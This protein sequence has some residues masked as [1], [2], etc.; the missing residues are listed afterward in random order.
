MEL[1]M[2]PTF[3]ISSLKIISLTYCQPITNRKHLLRN[4]AELLFLLN[5][6]NKDIVS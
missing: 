3:P 4:N 2:N 5:H 6:K 1:R